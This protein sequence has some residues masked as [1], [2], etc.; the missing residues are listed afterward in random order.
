VTRAASAL[1]GLLAWGLVS[2]G[3]QPAHEVL[4]GPAG[5]FSVAAAPARVADAQVIEGAVLGARLAL[6]RMGLLGEQVFPRL[7]V[8]VLRLDE[9]S[10]GIRSGTLA[11]ADAGPELAGGR[12]PLAR[13]TTLTLVGRAHVEPS[14]GAAPS[15]ETG[16]ISVSAVFAA[17]GDARLDALRRD[18]MS[19][20]LAL[21]LGME[22]AGRILG[23]PTPRGEGMWYR[24]SP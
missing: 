15:D 22:L 23:Y 2:C 18:D 9:S 16:E 1:A 6:S 7:R 10:G 20:E 12:A 5:G 8:E 4:A 17:E 11:S 13:G 19:R 21:R 14:E 24:P 3:Y